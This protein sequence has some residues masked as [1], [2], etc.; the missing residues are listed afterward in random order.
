MSSFTIHD[1]NTAPAQSKAILEGAQKSMGFVPNMFGVLA[2]S[3]AALE[4]YTSLATLQ[5]QKTDFSETERQ[6]LFLSI[7]AHNTCE[8][9][10]AAHSAI[11]KGKKV[12][13]SVVEAVRRGTQLADPKLEALR[14][15]ATTVV[16]K[17]GFPGD[18][19]LEAFRA[20]GYEDR[21]V[22]E[23]ILAVAF[24]TISNFTNHVAGTPLD[25]AFQPV[26]W[27]AAA[28]V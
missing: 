16:D 25:D 21:H 13:D 19:A 20:A 27:S 8:Y 3:P 18:A 5:D 1:A 6:V 9:C 12:D 15:F 24:K 4:A 28:A 23:V 14:T 22:L 2:A 17:R 10:V 7:S 11:S 26:A